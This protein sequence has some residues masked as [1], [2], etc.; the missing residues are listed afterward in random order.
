MKLLRLS[1]SLSRDE[2]I[3]KSAGLKAVPISPQL[4]GR[5]EKLELAHALAEKSFREKSNLAKS[6]EL[7]FLLWLSSE[8]DLRKAFAKNDFSPSD[9]IVVFLGKCSKREALR[10]L[11]AEEKPLALEKKAGALELETVSLSRVM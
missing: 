8:N 5:L 10:E 2:I 3:S 1:S 11:R 6:M 4:A 9:F 7:E